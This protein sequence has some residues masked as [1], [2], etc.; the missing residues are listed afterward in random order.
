MDS[1]VDTYYGHI[2]DSYRN[3]FARL[4]NVFLYQSVLHVVL[5]KNHKPIQRYFFPALPP[6]TGSSR[7]GSV[8]SR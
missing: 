5:Y 2:R 6:H 1:D 4:F 8:M 7:G 3:H